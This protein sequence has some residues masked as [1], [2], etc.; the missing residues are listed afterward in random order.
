M[1]GAELE[2][3]WAWGGAV[4]GH[5]GT[6]WPEA[7][8]AGNF[9]LREGISQRFFQVGDKRRQIVGFDDFGFGGSLLRVRVLHATGAWKVSSCSETVSTS[10]TG[11]DST[12]TSNPSRIRRRTRPRFRRFQVPVP[13]RRRICLAAASI[14][15]RTASKMLRSLVRTLQAGECGRAWSLHEM[16]A[17]E[18]NLFDNFGNLG[19]AILFVARCDSRC[20]DCRPILRPRAHGDDAA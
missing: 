10:A 12:S 8:A 1:P 18:A 19:R 11:A 9:G 14:W 17:V 2:L 7:G 13:A 5:A 16:F 4:C 3:P 20:F 6:S 15:M